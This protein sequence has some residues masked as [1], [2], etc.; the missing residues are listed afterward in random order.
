M[1][2]PASWRQLTDGQ[3]RSRQARSHCPR[4]ARADS[5]H[6][7]ACGLGSSGRLALRHRHPDRALLRPDEVRSQEADVGRSRPLHPLQRALRARPVL[8][9]GPGG[10]LP[11]EPPPHPAQAGQ[12]APGA[13]RS[14]GPAGHRGGHRLARP[15]TLGR[16]GHGA[17]AQAGQQ[18]LARVLRAGG[19]REP[20]GASL[21]KPHVRP[22]ARRSR[23][24]PGQPVR[25][26][27]LQR[28]PARQLREEDPRPRAH[29]RQGQELRLARPRHQW[30]RPR[31]DRQGPRPGGGDQGVA[32]LHRGPHR[33]G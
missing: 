33:Q 4:R 15:G 19:R 9:H 17:R 16:G 25:H 23:P 24:S 22:Q 2:S 1:P 18:E 8:L 6:A 12:P 32:H 30:P 21:G 7:D 5:P 11:G 14:R 26:P 10:L 28:H 29:H 27:G 13:S 31:P 20:G 3:S